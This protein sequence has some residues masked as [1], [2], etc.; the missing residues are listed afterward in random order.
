VTQNNLFRF[1]VFA[2]VSS[3]P[4]AREDKASLGD[5]VKTARAAG[6]Q[7]GGAETSGPFILDGY[8]RTGY[9]NLSDALEDIPPLA[10]AVQEAE[11][12]CYDVLIMDNIER[13][14]DLAPMLSTLF[15]KHKKQIHSARQSGPV[16]DPTDYDPASDES[17]DIM[18]HV[19]GI[20]QKYRINKLRRGW[21]I[22]IPRRLERGLPPFR[23]PFG[24][25][26]VGKDTPPLQNQ[27]AHYVVKMKGWLLEGRPLSWIAEQLTAAGVPPPNQKNTRW[28]VESIRH[29]LLNPFYAGI[30][31]IGQKRQERG[32]K[33][34]RLYRQRT[35]SSEWTRGRGAHQALWEEETLLAIQNEFARRMGLKNYAKVTYPLAGLL[36]CTTCKQKL[37]RRHTS[38]QG[39]LLPALGCKRGKAHVII[40]YEEAMH[41]LA[42]ELKKEVRDQ[43]LN[44]RKVEQELSRLQAELADLQERRARVHEGYES[45]MYK[46]EEASPKIKELERL[47]HTAQR[48]LERLARSQ[49]TRTEAQFL[50]AGLARMNEEELYIWIAEDDPAIVNRLLSALCQTIWV[51]PDHH[52]KIEW[53]DA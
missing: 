52:M 25:D 28:H 18:I 3:D 29:I 2:A 50:A 46:I 30:V 15:K 45:G 44:P 16:R 14:G 49:Q 37:I 38:W 36:R 51:D 5:Q 31:A 39:R 12:N 8:S 19:E 7:Q 53:R 6:L 41:L 26:R 27:S 43:T 1:A 22:G 40:E 9:V 48:Q 34:Q 35:A 47:E 42:L 24:Y 23:V 32:K 11:Q 4:Q 10:E 20:I 33:N 17:S 21:N 13:M